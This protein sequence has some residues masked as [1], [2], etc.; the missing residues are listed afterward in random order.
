MGGVQNIVCQAFFLWSC[1]KCDMQPVF[2]FFFFIRLGLEFRDKG[3]SFLRKEQEGPYFVPAFE[4]YR[5]SF[6]RVQ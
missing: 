6:K 1:N 3:N 2:F 5:Q 4:K